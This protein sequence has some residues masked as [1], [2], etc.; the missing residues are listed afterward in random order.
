MSAAGPARVKRALF[1]DRLG[2]ATRMVMRY[3]HTM[4][5]I[6][7]HMGPSASRALGQWPQIV[8]R[9]IEPHWARLTGPIQLG[10]RLVATLCFLFYQAMLLEEMLRRQQIIRKIRN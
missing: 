2:L 5:T 7:L 4:G 1:L 3:I 10:A 6:Y 9:P 8:P